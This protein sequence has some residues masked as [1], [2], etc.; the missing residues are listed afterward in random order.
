MIEIPK[1]LFVFQETLINEYIF[2][3]KINITH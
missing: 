2:W 3:L 1:V